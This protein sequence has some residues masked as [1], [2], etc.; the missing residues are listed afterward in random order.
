MSLALAL[1][2]TKASSRVHP[3]RDPRA[4]SQ[5]VHSGTHP[6][7]ATK[8]PG[9]AKNHP[10]SPCPNASHPRLPPDAPTPRPSPHAHISLWSLSLL[11]ETRVTD[12]REEDRPS[13]RPVTAP[14]TST[15]HPRGRIAWRAGLVPSLEW[16]PRTRLHDE[17]GETLL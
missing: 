15:A 10:A 16:S 14:L 17:P 13:P 4:L 5:S 12:L 11:Q 2:F 6:L 3:S 8:P 9:Q 7:P 1:K